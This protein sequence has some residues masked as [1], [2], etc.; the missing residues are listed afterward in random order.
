VYRK[1]VRRRRAVLTLLIIGS[2]LLL[3]ITYG[4]GSNGL[5]RGVS[6]VFSPLETVADRALKPARD[7]VDW[8][9]KTFEARGEN[10]DLRAELAKA[11]AQAAAGQEALHENAQ[12]R[13]LLELDRGPT[14]AASAYKPVTGRVEQV[15]ARIGPGDFFGE[16]SLFDRSPRSATIQADSDAT[17]L[18]L[19]R[20]APVGFAFVTGLAGSTRAIGDFFVVRAARRRRIGYDAAREVLARHPGRWEIGFQ[21]ENRG[22]PEFWRR[23]AT[24]VAGD[25]WREELR[26]VPG[27]PH[28]PH[29]HVIV[30][31]A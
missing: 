14:L 29:D 23:V 18:V 11:R 12:L 1:Q 5:Q 30:L 21:A 17:L 15:L 25:T 20:E 28:I 7:L 10:A 8:F 27:K 6:T 2:F 4:S 24:D 26:P 19:D 22:A 31:T 9:D 16:M 13:K 3:T